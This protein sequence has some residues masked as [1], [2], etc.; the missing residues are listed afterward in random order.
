MCLHQFLLLHKLF[1]KIVL[2]EG[3]AGPEWQESERMNI[4]ISVDFLFCCETHQLS[5]SRLI[6]STLKAKNTFGI[7]D[8]SWKTAG[9]Q[10]FFLAMVKPF[11]IFRY[12]YRHDRMLLIQTNFPILR[13]FYKVTKEFRTT[14]TFP[15]DSTAI[16]IT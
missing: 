9:W 8:T 15:E 14:V 6:S 4:S 13:L 5:S 3:S 1:K 11:I 7:F 12:Y 2:A 16:L 10:I